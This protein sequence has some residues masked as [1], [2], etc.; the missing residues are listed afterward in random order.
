MKC[1]DICE[2]LRKHPM[3]VK[4]ISTYKYIIVETKEVNYVQVW[5]DSVGIAD[6]VWYTDKDKALEHAWEVLGAK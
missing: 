2:R 5:E 4:R 6:V 1:I 3:S